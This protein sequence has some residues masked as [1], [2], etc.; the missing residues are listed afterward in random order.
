MWLL[1]TP[2]SVF[3]SRRP[4]PDDDWKVKHNRIVH[5]FPVFQWYSRLA[6]CIDKCDN[7][8]EGN[9]VAA[10]IEPMGFRSVSFM[11]VSKHMDPWKHAML[12]TVSEILASPMPSTNQREI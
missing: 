8:G 12:D 11:H 1:T 3:I 7:L 5:L 9:L 2:D 6:G 10:V 4:S